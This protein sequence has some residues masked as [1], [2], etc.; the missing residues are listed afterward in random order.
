VVVPFSN[1]SFHSHQ[2]A[3]VHWGFRLG[4]DIKNAE[5]KQLDQGPVET[6]VSDDPIDCETSDWLL[7]KRFAKTRL[8]PQTRSSLIFGI[9]LRLRAFTLGSQSG[10]RASQSA[11][12]TA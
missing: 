11:Y 5:V 9:A 3:Q 10:Y 8:Q 4:N 12:R 1:L 2:L 6:L 7:E